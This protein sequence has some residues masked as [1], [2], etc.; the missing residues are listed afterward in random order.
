MPSLAVVVAQVR[1]DLGMGGGQIRV[2]F[3]F[4]FGLERAEAG[5]HEGVVIAVLRAAQAGTGV[6]LGVVA[7]AADAQ[8]LAHHR[9]GEAGLFQLSDHGVDLPH[10]GWLKMA[11][12]FFKMSRSRSVRRSCSSS[13]R[14]RIS[15][16]EAAVPAWSSVWAFQRYSNEV[17][18]R[19]RFSATDTG[20]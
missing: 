12:A 17:C 16:A 19:P 9:H 18:G 13:C 10:V 7:G 5:L 1:A 8:R 2:H 4:Q 6:R 20:E 14:T 11:K 3:H 15:R